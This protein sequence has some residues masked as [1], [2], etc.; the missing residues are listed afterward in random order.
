MNLFFVAY[1]KKIVGTRYVQLIIKLESHP[2]F[3]DALEAGYCLATNISAR[4][5]R[6]QLKEIAG[7]DMSIVVLPIAGG[8]WAVSAPTAELVDWLNQHADM[9]VSH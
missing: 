5:L 7:E 8:E 4:D 2:H 1:D 6:D 9:R 3:V